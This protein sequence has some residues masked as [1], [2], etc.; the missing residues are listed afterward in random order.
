MAVKLRLLYG[1]PIVDIDVIFDGRKLHIKN[2]LLDTGSA[3]TILDA[4]VV[5]EIGVKP[6]GTDKTA[7]IHGVG[8]T[9]IVFTKWFDSVSL[10]DWFV[11]S[12]KIEIGVMDYGIDI[13]GIIGFDF[14]RAAKL[15][16]DTD[17]MLVYSSM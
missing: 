14:L 17:K 4:D 10:G 2:V 6:E 1:L 9:E 11:K 15:V 3:G 16:I 7:I 12:C 8:G 5:S 13:Q